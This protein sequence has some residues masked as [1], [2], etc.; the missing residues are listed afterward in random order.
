MLVSVFFHRKKNDRKR[1]RHLTP[2]L[3]IVVRQIQLHYMGT[4]GGNLTLV[5]CPTNPTATQHQH[6]GQVQSVWW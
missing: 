3:Q 6:T 1:V 5:S 4:E 2:I